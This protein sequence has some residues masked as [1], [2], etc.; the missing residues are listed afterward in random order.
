VGDFK[1]TCTEGNAARFKEWILHRGGVAV[2]SSHSMSDPGKS[3]STPAED[4]EGGPISRPRWDVGDK[5]DFVVTDAKDIG[6]I[7]EREVKRFHVAVRR[8]SNNPFLFK[9]TDASSRRIK[10][11]LKKVD[12]SY[13][14]FDYETQECVILAPAAVV[15]LSEWTC[16]KTD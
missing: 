9:C 14:T 16:T 3:Y 2:W 11:E 15:P 7:T 6:V 5:P 1:H 10:K 13:Y 4:L 8:G 12:G